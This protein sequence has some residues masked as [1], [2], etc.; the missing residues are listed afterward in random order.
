M[1]QACD[2]N[3]IRLARR[4]PKLGAVNTYRNA[5][6]A[7]AAAAACLSLAACSAGITTGSSASADAADSSRSAAAVASSASA[8]AI[9]SASASASRAAAGRMI[10]VAGT[11]ATIPVPT[12]AK[13]VANMAMNVDG[14]KQTGIFFVLVTPAKVASF[15]TATLPRDG[16]KITANTLITQSG[17]AVAFVQ[18]SG[19]GIKGTIDSVAKFPD[20]VGIPGLGHKNVTSVTITPR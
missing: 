8:A 4:R 5:A 2:T 16:Y 17:S 15:Y 14:G 20:S 3:A 1:L 7:L 18:F 13:V 11:S 19:H 9:A 12:G 6:A 10:K